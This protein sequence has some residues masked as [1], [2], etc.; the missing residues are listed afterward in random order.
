MNKK[1]RSYSYLSGI[2]AIILLSLL[3]TYSIRDDKVKVETEAERSCSSTRMLY[4]LGGQ[5]IEHGHIKILWDKPECQMIVQALQTDSLI[6]NVQ[7][8][9]PNGYELELLKSGRTQIKV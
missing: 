4:P 8:P 3:I 1:I 5:E 2:T 9:V 6:H 7:K